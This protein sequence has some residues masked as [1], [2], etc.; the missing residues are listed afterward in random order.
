MRHGNPPHRLLVSKYSH[1]QITQLCKPLPQMKS[2]ELVPKQISIH[3]HSWAQFYCSFKI[4]QPHF[5]SE[6]PSSLTL[7]PQCSRV[8]S[9]D[10]YSCLPR[11]L[12]ESKGPQLPQEVF[13]AKKRAQQVAQHCWEGFLTSQHP[14]ERLRSCFAL[15]ILE[16]DHWAPETP[17]KK[18]L[19]H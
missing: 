5:T 4:I 1:L 7:L 3:K 15:I 16:K 6:I 11:V 9:L 18:V 8:L 13:K 19:L 12:W 14:E 10:N 2:P 17:P